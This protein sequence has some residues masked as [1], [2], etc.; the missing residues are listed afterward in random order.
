MALMMLN[1]KNQL[2]LQKNANK[3]VSVF[4]DRWYVNS[5]TRELVDRTLAD[6]NIRRPG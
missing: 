3:F 6:P 5:S 4:R 2:M 1:A